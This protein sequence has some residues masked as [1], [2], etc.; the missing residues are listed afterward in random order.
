LKSFSPAQRAL[1][2]QDGF[3]LNAAFMIGFPAQESSKQS[4][5]RIFPTPGIKDFQGCPPS[6]FPV[7]GGGGPAAPNNRLLLQ[8]TLCSLVSR[9]EGSRHWFSEGE[10]SFLFWKIPSILRFSP[11]RGVR[12]IFYEHSK[13]IFNMGSNETWKFRCES[14]FEYKAKK[15]QQ[16]QSGKKTIMRI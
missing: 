10:N 15:T 14:K 16:K 13:P 12:L 3:P 7:R 9:P 8:K 11:V 5:D 2:N 4:G 1:K 6:R